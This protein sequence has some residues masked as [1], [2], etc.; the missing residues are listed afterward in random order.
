M[1]IFIKNKE[2]AKMFGLSHDYIGQLL[3]LGKV[4]GKKIDGEWRVDQV[5]LLLYIKNSG[6]KN[7]VK[8]R[9]SFYL[10]AYKKSIKFFYTFIFLIVVTITYFVF[11]SSEPKSTEVVEGDF[12]LKKLDTKVGEN[13]P[14]SVTSFSD[15]SGGL[16]ISVKELK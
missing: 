4:E 1:A 12:N 3:R 9:S 14:Y 13:L 7:S 15:E 11:V 8:K 16:N 10:V 6:K 2:A 5:S